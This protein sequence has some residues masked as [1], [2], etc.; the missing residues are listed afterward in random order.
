MPNCLHAPMMSG[1]LLFAFSPQGWWRILSTITHF[2]TWPRA[3]V[4]AGSETGDE[5][6]GEGPVNTMSIARALDGLRTTD[7]SHSPPQFLLALAL[8]RPELVVLGAMQRMPGCEG[9]ASLLRTVYQAFARR[10]HVSMHYSHPLGTRWLLDS[11][12]CRILSKHRPFRTSR[13]LLQWPH[14][15]APTSTTPLAHTQSTVAA[16]STS[17]CCSRRAS[18]PSP[19]LPYCCLSPPSASGTCA[20]KGSKFLRAHCCL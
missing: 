2:H 4:G 5:S 16:A 9:R 14:R 10:T 17:P 3:H 18:S 1:R 20:R 6:A 19:R 15:C 8:P 7:T 12:H 13:Q 11:L